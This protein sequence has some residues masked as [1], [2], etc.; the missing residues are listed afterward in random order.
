MKLGT[1]F[2]LIS[3]Q[4]AVRNV[5]RMRGMLSSGGQE[6]IDHASFAFVLCSR[7]LWY[8]YVTTTSYPDVMERKLDFLACSF[9]LSLVIK[10]GSHM[11]LSGDGRA[12]LGAIWRRRARI[13]PMEGAWCRRWRWYKRLYEP[14]VSA[15]HY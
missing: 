8:W 3:Y 9:F 11:F 15:Q 14:S 5:S 10:V 4:H 12:R 7:Q 13:T 2:M 1:L 6:K